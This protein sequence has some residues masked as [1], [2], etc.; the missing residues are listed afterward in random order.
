MHGE[1]ESWI[2]S[3][4]DAIDRAE[5]GP[6]DADPGGGII[7]Q[8]VARTGQGRS[9]GYR[10]LPAYRSGERAVLLYGFARTSGIT[11]MT[12]SSSH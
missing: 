8:R 7:K 10:L 3:L 4:V 1:N 5:K 9:S 11:S 6:V 2:Y 12:T